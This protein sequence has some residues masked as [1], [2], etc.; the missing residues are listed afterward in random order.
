[1]PFLVQLTDGVP[2]AEFPVTSD[3]ITMGRQAD[4]R[5]VLKDSRVSRKHAIVEAT[6]EGITLR[7]LE[8][9][10][11]TYVNEEPIRTH[12]L[13]HGDKIS[14][15][16]IFDFLYFE[17]ED[18]QLLNQ[19]LA[20]GAAPNADQSAYSSVLTQEMGNL[21]SS[22]QGDQLLDSQ[23]ARQLHNKVNK[24]VAELKSLYE[25]TN[26][27]SVETDL[28][29]VLE[30]VVVHVIKATKAERGFVMLLSAEKELIPVMARNAR[31]MLD[32]TERKQFSTTLANKA[33]ELKRTLVSKDTSADPEMAT[34]SVVD[35]NI[36]S[37]ICA[38]LI[39]RSEQIGVLYVD[40]KDSIKSFTE[41][42][43]DFFEAL[44][45]QASIAI[46][47][48]R[49]LSKLSNSNRILR[50]KVS[51][52]EAMFAVSQ[53]L[54]FGEDQAEVL[55]TVLDQAIRV[56]GS[57]R[58]SI[59]LLDTN[60]E[61]LEVSVLRG[62]V[63]PEMTARSRL[64]LGEGIA[65]KVAQTGKPYVANA[66]AGD[67]HF[68]KKADRD[69][70]VKNLICAPLAGKDGNIGVLTLVNK[71]QGEFNQDDLHIVGSL[72]H[73][74]AVSIEKARLYN[75][76]VYDGLT[77]V[78][79]VR[80]FRAWMETEINKG[81]RH[82]NE[83]TLLIMD[84][85]HFKSFND[86]HGHQVG[87]QVLV[88]LASIFKDQARTSD[89][90]ARYGGEEFVIALPETDLPGAEIF[91]E[92]LRERVQN[93]KVVTPTQELSVT[94]SIGICNLKVSGVKNLD[95]MVKAAD[96][97]LYQAKARGRNTWVSYKPA[98]SSRELAE[99]VKRK[100]TGK[101]KAVD[102]KDALAG[103]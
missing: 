64:R 45:G 5:V 2:S 32:E 62:D 43:V 42:D 99:Q 98:L 50:R 61:E 86:T 92:R 11:L 30:L 21:L 95:E 101:M 20:G 13:A 38:P 36:R 96:G 49:L 35:Y 17:K 29:R 54:S 85:D 58:G 93:H 84:V 15:A 87:D 60:T 73:H 28:Q 12:V 10:H 25:I 40:A 79:V 46:Q 91:A 57:Q 18:E 77:K 4:N 53:S 3:A 51:E 83:L 9:T 6:G 48:A 70:D 89:L 100:M 1:M 71:E 19:L 24:V 55:E 63:K 33:L 102:V 80:Y 67:E 103:E 59:M 7:D 22:L 52:L 68:V 41:K 72:A 69:D 90:V 16:Q 81:L 97:C 75:L 39:V 26:A 8:S 78:H 44:T 88:E 37:C 56:V 76:A 74:A 14:V 27:I 82:G 65:G 47:N 66:G 31:D 94:I 34:K 23:V